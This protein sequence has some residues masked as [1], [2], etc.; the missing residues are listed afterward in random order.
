MSD[1]E[2]FTERE[3][4]GTPFAA[5]LIITPIEEDG[6]AEWRGQILF[7]DDTFNWESHHPDQVGSVDLRILKAW[8]YPHLKSSGT[9]MANILTRWHGEIVRLFHRVCQNQ[10]GGS[11]IGTVRQG[12]LPTIHED[13]ILV[14]LDE[15]GS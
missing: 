4:E 2:K 12:R 15:A 10:K 1:M 6:G 7:D 5:T 13:D 9:L 8:D 14:D 3:G 11:S